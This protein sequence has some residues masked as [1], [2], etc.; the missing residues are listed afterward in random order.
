M[1]LGNLVFGNSRGRHP[2]DRGLQDIFCEMLL[3]PFGMSCYGYPEDDMLPDWTELPAPIGGYTNG[4]FIFRPY[5]WGDCQCGWEDIEGNFDEEHQS[6]CYQTKLDGLRKVHGKEV[7]GLIHVDFDCKPYNKARTELCKEFNLDPLNG[8]EVHCTCDFM[9][10]YDA[11]F[12]VNKL[13]ENGHSENCRIIL[14]N[15]ECPDV[16]LTVTVYKY[17]L[18]DSYSNIPLDERLIKKMANLIKT[19]KMMTV[20]S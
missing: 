1:E 2:V 13:G 18:R 8:C 12:A 11:W 5:F 6:T 15:F 9:A 4:T 17:F 20:K 10:R 7:N 19:K 16:G 3:E 14:P